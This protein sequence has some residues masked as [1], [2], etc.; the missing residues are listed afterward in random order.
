M[1]ENKVYYRI[2]EISRKTNIASHTIRYWENEFSFFLK[3]VRNNRGQRLYTEKELENI[4]RLKDLLYQHGYRISAVKKVLRQKES[5][6]NKN[7]ASVPVKEL[8]VGLKRMDRILT[9]LKKI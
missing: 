2:G 4:V 8:L 7:G 5:K 1:S 3:P 9:Q 6:K